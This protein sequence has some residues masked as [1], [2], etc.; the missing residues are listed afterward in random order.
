MS[1]PTLP[2]RQAIEGVAAPDPEGVAVL[3]EIDAFLARY[4]AFPSDEARWAAALWA[5]HT[6][7]MDAWSSTP[8]LN[9]MSPEKQSGKTRALEVLGLL[10]WKPLHAVSISAAALYRVISTDQPTLLLD[11]ADTY[12]G[13]VVAK[14][15]E[16]LRGLINAGHRKGAMVYRGEVAGKKVNV[17]EFPAY[18]ACALAGIGDLPDTIV[19]RS[20]II[21]M[22]RRASGEHIEPFRS[23]LVEPVANRLQERLAEWVG[24]ASTDW[25]D[26][27]PEM[28]P[29]ITDRPADV[30]EPLLIVA[31][32]AGGHWPD[33]ARRAC[34][35]LNA[36]RVASDPSPGVILLADCR[37][38]FQ[39]REVDRLTTEQLLEA[40]TSLDESPWGDLRGKPL[41]ARGLARRLRK[42]DIRPGDHRFVDATRKGY[43]IEDFHDAWSRYLSP[44]ADV[45]HVAHA[46]SHKGDP[47]P[48]A[49]PEDGLGDDLLSFIDTPS[50]SVPQQGQQGQ[51]AQLEPSPDTEGCPA[52]GGA[53]SRFGGCSDF[54][55][56]R[57][58]AF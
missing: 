58:Q 7:A 2:R 18:A 54:G 34:L 30:W 15:H 42:Y 9:L 26:A 40:L 55:C 13:V 29:G 33:R 50:E 31:D 14:Q 56:E 46:P 16:D 38:I 12:L 4:V 51:Q 8:R 47:E 17:V 57:F 6:H 22:R 49:P 3:D 45:A 37:R 41:D 5:A 39:S 43:R 52:C 44:V 21:R 10:V 25:A 1:A 27:W 11:E 24:A 48:V 53:E 36:Q 23:R 20:V 28:P 19:D 35:M 32:A